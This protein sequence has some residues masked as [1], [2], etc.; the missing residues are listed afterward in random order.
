MCGEYEETSEHILVS[1]H[2]AYIIWQSIATWVR[3][4]PI[5]AFEVK[6]LL[7]LHWFSPGSRKRKKALYAVI[8]VGFWCIW[9]TRNEAVFGQGSPSITKV[10]D[11]VKSL[12]YLWVKN[13][14]KE[15][16]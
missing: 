4:P 11:E 7:T 14:S 13:R 16:T 9:K 12:A 5:I 1:C 15:R 8:L 2:F 3:I 10:L 6:D